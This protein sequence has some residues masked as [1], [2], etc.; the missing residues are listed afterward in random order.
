MRKW[1]KR[2]RWWF[3]LGVLSLAFVGISLIPAPPPVRPF[4]R[5]R[6][7]MTRNEVDAAIG[8]IR[9]EERYGRHILFMNEES[10]KP[11]PRETE[12]GRF[13]TFETGQLTVGFLGDRAAY[14]TSISSSPSRTLWAKLRL[15][16]NRFRGA[17]AKGP[18]GTTVTKRV[19][20]P[21]T[22]ASKTTQSTATTGQGR[23]SP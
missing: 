2:W 7:G 11:A 19:L 13:Y 10:A 12:V 9:K 20:S 15:L 16:F 5:I 8:E 22:S 18:S 6:I 23:P 1:L 14:K 4:D 3:L 17:P 21:R